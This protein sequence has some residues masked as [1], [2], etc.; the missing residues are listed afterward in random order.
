MLLDNKVYKR[1]LTFVILSPS[2]ADSGISLILIHN[3]HK[4]RGKYAVVILEQLQVILK[5]ISLV[6]DDE[7]T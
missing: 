5:L 7:W 1:T 4:F 6:T 3:A 2:K